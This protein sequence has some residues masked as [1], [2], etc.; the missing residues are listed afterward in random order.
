MVN[1]EAKPKG[2]KNENFTSDLLGVEVLLETNERVHLFI[3]KIID[4]HGEGQSV[5]ET[6]MFERENHMY[7]VM[8][9][10]LSALLETA[11]PGCEPIGPRHVFSTTGVIVLEDLSASGFRILDKS[12]GL[13]LE[14]GLL[15]MRTLARF[16]SASF[17]L[18]Q[19][20]P[21]IFKMYDQHIFTEPAMQESVIMDPKGDGQSVKDSSMFDR[22]KHMYSVVLPKMSELLEAAIP[23]CEQIA[24]RHVFSNTGVLVLEDLSASGFGLKDRLVGLD[25]HHTLLVLRT[26]ARFHSVSLV[27]HQ[28]DPE[29]FELY[30][31]QIFTEP[32]MEQSL[33]PFCTD[34][35]RLLADEIVNWPGFGELYSKKIREMSGRMIQL[36]EEAA[37]R[38]DDRFN[39]LTH[40]DLWINN[41]MFR[42]PDSVRFIDFQMPHFASIGNDLQLFINS[43]TIPEVRRNHIDTLLKEYYKTFCDTLKA[44]DYKG[45]ILTF[46]DLQEEFRKSAP[47]SLIITMV[48]LPTIYADNDADIV[49]FESEGAPSHS[50]LYDNI[51]I[52]ET[53][54][55][56]LHYFEKQGASVFDYKSF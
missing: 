39:V 42:S 33:G 4:T 5:K 19:Q 38:R 49:M 28:Q 20:E 46:E 22:E 56:M 45:K 52:K 50:K 47:Y 25:L 7:S 1:F 53:M 24:P 10:K 36:A 44:L 48:F 8:L 35:T 3:K 18:H 27:I 34:M 21:E 37:R 17:V 51:R 9:P 32:A 23:G 43:S 54:I 13:D 11:V 15:V 41:M 16:H 30:K 2:G 12:I 26:L 40:D 14:Q 55:E 6:S 29:C 31:H